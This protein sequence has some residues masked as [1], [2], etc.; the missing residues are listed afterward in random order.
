[1]ENGIRN[2]NAVARKLGPASTRTTNDRLETVREEKQKR[3]EMM[4]RR[5]AEATV[6]KRRR[7]RRGISSSSEEED[8][9]DTGD[10]TDPDQADDKYPLQL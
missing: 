10:D 6:A 9:S 4:E 3:K 5:K 2:A 8:K 7:A 1:M